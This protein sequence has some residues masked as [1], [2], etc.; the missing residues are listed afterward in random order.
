MA[1]NKKSPKVDAAKLK[2]EG[3]PETKQGGFTPRTEASDPE[4]E[5]E[6][7]FGG[8][9]YDDESAHYDELAD[10]ASSDDNYF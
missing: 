3:A 1:K 10:E 8:D 7:N 5:F 6:D 4:P 2:K 9:D